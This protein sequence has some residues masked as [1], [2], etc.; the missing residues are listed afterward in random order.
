M[1]H[2][3]ARESRIIFLLL[4]TL[5]ITYNMANATS[6]WTY[7]C[8]CLN[9]S[10]HDIRIRPHDKIIQTQ[11]VVYNPSSAGIV[12][13]QVDRTE[14]AIGYPNPS[15]CP[16]NVKA[17]ASAAIYQYVT[18]STGGSASVE[19]KHSAEFAFA[20]V[21]PSIGFTGGF[22]VNHQYTVQNGIV[23]T[24]TYA[25]ANPDYITIP[26]WSIRRI[27]ADYIK[28][29]ASVSVHQ[30]VRESHAGTCLKCGLRTVN[31]GDWG[32]EDGSS[33]GS[34]NQQINMY[35]DPITYPYVPV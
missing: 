2:S 27:L 18:I 13:D 28:R 20:V 31:I 14:F 7:S 12:Y 19:Y 17:T 1:K 26:A 11:D 29:Y 22:S 15:D 21:A 6:S 10:H 30:S 34:R 9:V 16:V 4:I 3:I 23:V 5:S 32:G 35:L 24:G 33:S 25:P 8:D